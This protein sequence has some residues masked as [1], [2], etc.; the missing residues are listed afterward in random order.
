MQEIPP[1][2]KTPDTG[3]ELQAAGTG[4][5]RERL[6]H[7]FDLERHFEQIA[8]VIVVRPYK[9]LAASLVLTLLMGGGWSL[10]F[11]ETRPEKQWVPRGAVALTH[12]DYVE[13]T[14]PGELSFSA[15]IATPAGDSNML[16]AKVMKELRQIDRR[17]KELKVD[18]GK[19]A[20]AEFPDI[21]QE[22]LAKVSAPAPKRSMLLACLPV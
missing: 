14:W 2:M 16:S 1:V 11:N 7:A 19:A 17:I 12:K 13:M 10:Q 3:R 4:T 15:W 5:T 18:G 22:A 21:S 8:R 20:R 6:K 9:F